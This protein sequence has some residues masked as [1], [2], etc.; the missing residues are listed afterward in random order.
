[1]RAN[2]ESAKQ[3][4][5]VFPFPFFNFAMAAPHSRVRGVQTR[6]FEAE[7]VKEIRGPGFVSIFFSFR[8][9]ACESGNVNQG[10]C[11]MSRMCGSQKQQNLSEQLEHCLKGVGTTNESRRAAI[12]FLS[13]PGSRLLYSLPANHF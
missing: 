4:L 7:K 3:N 9:I 11:G 5:V 12:G 1:L 10:M 6:N 13:P 8:R 2:A